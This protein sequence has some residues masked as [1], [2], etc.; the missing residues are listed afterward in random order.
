MKL[1]RYHGKIYRIRKNPSD[2][3]ASKWADTIIP[4]ALL[5]AGAAAMIYLI[6]IPYFQREA[7]ELPP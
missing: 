6:L 1:I 7:K 5:S 3:F 2:V 4:A